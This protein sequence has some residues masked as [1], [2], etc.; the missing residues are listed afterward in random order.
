MRKIKTKP[1]IGKRILAGLMDYAIIFT[2]TYIFAATYGEPN[3][4]GGYT[5]EGLPMLIPIGFWGIM[6]VGIEQ[7]FGATL[8]NYLLDLKPI[9]INGIQEE[10]T[11]VQSFKRHL[12]DLIDMFCFGLIGIMIIKNTEMNQRLGDLWAKTIVVNMKEYIE[13]NKITTE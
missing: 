8:G 2:F 9:S 1:N 4:D 5:V 11:I 13:L 10:L 6:I 7:F 12:V 3:I